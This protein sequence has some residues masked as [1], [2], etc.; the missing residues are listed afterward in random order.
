[1]CPDLPNI[2]DSRFKSL[3]KLLVVP[4]IKC[5]LERANPREDAKI[6]SASDLRDNLHYPVL[7][8]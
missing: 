5:K 7:E 1:M 6:I 2:R 3:E 8:T 4:L